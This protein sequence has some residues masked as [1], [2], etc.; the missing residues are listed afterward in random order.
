MNL[1][2]KT[3]G[4]ILSFCELAVGIL[5]LINPVGFTSS[6]IV[7][8]GVALIVLGASE[9]IRYFKTDPLQAALSQCLTRGS[10]ELLLGIFFVFKSGIII[11]AF[12]LLTILYAIGILAMGIAKLQWTVDMIRLKADKWWIPAIS[13]A[14]TIICAVII[15]FNPFASTAVLWV[16]IASALIAQA[17][18]DIISFFLAGRNVKDR[19]A[20]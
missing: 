14:I 15:L 3:G 5:L 9:I 7:F 6:I 10:V 12:A 16:F 13:C 20:F 17:V 19:K 1:S 8:A 18:I 11:G 2:S 4:I